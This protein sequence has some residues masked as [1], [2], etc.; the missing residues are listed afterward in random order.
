VARLLI[1]ADELLARAE[2]NGYKRRVRKEKD[3]VLNR[4]KHVRKT[5]KDQNMALNSY[6][7]YLAEGGMG[8]DA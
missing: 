6:A 7:S 4:Y 5:K 1:T 3:E 2:A 8:S